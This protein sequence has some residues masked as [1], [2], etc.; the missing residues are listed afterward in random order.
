MRASARAA[1]VP[2]MELAG[3]LSR[4]AEVQAI[5]IALGIPP[6]GPPG[7]V[8]DAAVAALQS[9]H[10]QYADPRGAAELCTALTR[11][12]RDSRQLE[13]DAERELTITCGATEGLFTSLISVTDP[14]DE[15][16]IF[17]PFFE[18]YPGM[19]ELAG[20]VPRVVPLRPPGWRIDLAAV[21]AAVTRR[22]RAILLNTPHNPTGR[23]FDATEI[24]GLIAICADRG[25]TL[26]TDEVYDQYVFDGRRHVSPLSLPGGADHGVVVCSL[27]KTLRMTGWRIG[28]CI[29]SAERTAVLRRVHER[30][31]LGT[32]RPLQLGAAAM[33]SSGVPDDRSSLQVQRDLIVTSLRSAGLWLYRAEGGWFLLADVTGL[34]RP[35]SALA[36]E[37]VRDA[38]VL[39]APGTPFFS[40]RDE[41]ERWIRVTFARGQSVTS[42]ALER[43]ERHLRAG[44]PCA[45][46]ATVTFNR[47]AVRLNAGQPR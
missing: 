33:I 25:L 7:P 11:W 37:L 41:G 28:F 38:K 16:I 14:G 6:A 27:S 36:G 43:I 10:H 3:L 21:R 9:G 23:A 13:V 35:A 19:V 44:Q 34:G 20:A 26:I 15:V 2:S 18:L 8:V 22:T 1:A 31:T 46:P 12:L 24:G 39:V 30:T 40:H 17:E 45:R 4:A 42:T 47:A 29:A 5:D 32:S